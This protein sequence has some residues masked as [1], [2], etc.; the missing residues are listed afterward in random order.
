[1]AAFGLL[2]PAGGGAA[3]AAHVRQQHAPACGRATH[4]QAAHSRGGRKA[5]RRSTRCTPHRQ[6]RGRRPGSL[7]AGALPDT[8]GRCHNAGLAPSA[9]NLQLVRLAVLC[10]VNRERIV[11]REAP[12]RPDGRLADAAQSHTESMAFG[13]YFEHDGPHGDTPLSRVRQTGYIYSSQIGYEIGENIGW[14][15]LW[16]GTPKAIVAAWMASPGHRANIL[17]PRFRDTGIG[18]SPHPPG[19]LAGGAHGG[20]YTQDFGVIF[21]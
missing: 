11:R 7:P 13:N 20:I 18:V 8:Q 16:L 15:T 9:G 21:G 2:A 19:S 5:N 10:L 4:V 3:T 17:D 6:L 14:G 12:L 1:M